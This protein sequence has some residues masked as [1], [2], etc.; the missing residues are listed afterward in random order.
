MSDTNNSYQLVNSETNLN[1]DSTLNIKEEQNND[2]INLETLNTNN[3]NPINNDNNI[4][5]NTNNNNNNENNNNENI[6]NTNNNNNNNNNNI[7]SN[8]DSNNNN[9]N[10][11]NETFPQFPQQNL[12]QP[13]SISYLSEIT[14]GNFMPSVLLL[15][16]NKIAINTPINQFTGETLLHMAC[17]F[18]YY[19]VVRC[20]IENFKADYNLKNKMGLTAFHCV[21]MNKSKDMMLLT[22]F[23]NLENIMIDEEDINGLT[24]LFYSVINNFNLAFL[25]LVAKNVNVKKLDNMGNNLLYYALISENF[26]VT[27][28]LLKH[29]PQDFNLN[30]SYLNHTIFLSDVLIKSKNNNLAKFLIKKYSDDIKIDS[31]SS[32]KKN[33][34][35]FVIYNKFIYEIFNTFYFY[36]N[37]NFL[38]FF[39]SLY[40]NLFKFSFGENNDN[41]NS[42]FVDSNNNNKIIYKNKIENF[43]LFF[44]LIINNNRKKFSYF[45]ISLIYLLFLFNFFFYSSFYSSI[46][47]LIVFSLSV[48]LIKKAF[49]NYLIDFNS[50]YKK[51]NVDDRSNNVF[52]IF[53]ETTKTNDILMLP[54]DEN[55]VCEFCLNLK[56]LNK[57][58]CM[59]CDNCIENYFLHSNLLN[60]CI[61]KKNVRFYLLI[62]IIILLNF[63]KIIYNTKSYL[64]YFVFIFIF[65]KLLGKIISILINIG[66][67]TTYFVSY[68]LHNYYSECDLLL[69]EESKY[70]PVPKMDLIK[71]KDFFNNLK[72]CLLFN[73]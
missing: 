54:A 49:K 62:L 32:C 72:N 28:F 25:Y 53:N 39:Q 1:S 44:Y 57:I 31:I 45:S 46:F 24:P 43:Y 42:N 35:E 17:N 50:N 69:R 64:I 29:F 3:D 51:F 7:I 67:N 61:H 19:N 16:Q 60:I 21:V 27:K 12:V 10:N 40:T 18:S 68:H 14:R 73:E 8:N 34:K 9:N 13:E 30:H 4:I 66:C 59:K 20:F 5:I 33:K 15:E 65:W 70:V 37:N 41:L 38:E 58:H 36:K 55:L 22:Y 48:L 2:S 52:K 26:F 11:N 56:T 23:I 71:L 6:I 47:Y 63:L